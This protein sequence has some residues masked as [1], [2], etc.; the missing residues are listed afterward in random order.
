MTELTPKLTDLEQSHLR[1]LVRDIQESATHIWEALVEI[2]EKHLWREYKS[3]R[4]FVVAELPFEKSRA[5][6]L[7]QAAQIREK[8]ST[9]VDNPAV[10]PANERQ[11]RPLAKL[12]DPEEQAAA[13]QDAVD[14]AGGEP[15]GAQVQ[16]VVDLYRADNEPP[17]KPSRQPIPAG[18]AKAAAKKALGQ[19]TRALESLGLLTGLRESL[20]RIRTSLR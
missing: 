8:L 2:H 7:I 3:F 1:G 9:M 18:E 6:Q 14:R 11:I 12:S 10:L 19:L 13:W 20:T 15:S 17:P 4:A 5:H 16:E